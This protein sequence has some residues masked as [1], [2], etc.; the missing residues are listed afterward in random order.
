MKTATELKEGEQKE[1]EL[2]RLCIS[3]WVLKVPH[4]LSVSH[5]VT[6]H[7]LYHFT[8]LSLLHDIKSSMSSFWSRLLNRQKTPTPLSH[9]W[10]PQ[11]LLWKHKCLTCCI[12]YIKTEKYNMLACQR[13]QRATHLAL[14]YLVIT[15]NLSYQGPTQH[16]TR[17]R[18]HSSLCKLY[19]LIV[20][21]VCVFCA[22]T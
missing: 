7:L 16:L 21:C 10:W 2:F 12:S 14:F 17:F 3:H 20:Q 11:L 9:L 1:A 15:Y 4:Q 22:Y 19:K 13:L 5:G 18:I 8:L 6:L